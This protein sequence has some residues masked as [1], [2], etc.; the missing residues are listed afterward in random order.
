MKRRHDSRQQINVHSYSYRS[1]YVK[2]KVREQST[3]VPLLPPM[4]ARDTADN[5]SSMMSLIISSRRRRSSRVDSHPAAMVLLFTSDRCSKYSIKRRPSLRPELTPH[6]RRGALALH[7]IEQR[8]VVERCC[9][10]QEVI[11]VG[12]AGGR[13][14]R[15]RE[16]EGV[17]GRSALKHNRARDLADLRK[18][19]RGSRAGDQVSVDSKVGKRRLVE[20]PLCTASCSY[21]VVSEHALSDVRAQLRGDGGR[22]RGSF[23]AG[24][25]SLRWALRRV[26]QGPN[27]EECDRVVRE[28]L[29]ELVEIDF[30]SP[31]RWA[32]RRGH[33]DYLQVAKNQSPDQLAAEVVRYLHAETAH[34]EGGATERG[35]QH[36]KVV[37]SV[38]PSPRGRAQ[39]KT[40]H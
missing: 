2:K 9:C 28:C 36:E 23:S 38:G 20:E 33:S 8:V 25:R 19:K 35:A 3:F 7:P 22:A 6:R 12:Q 14:E 29:C 5:Y 17:G 4:P 11:Q 15:E 24:E 39:N 27:L 37:L 1:Y 21:L 34:S 40:M 10:V 32:P 16:E 26:W 13:A 31:A 30:S 18:G